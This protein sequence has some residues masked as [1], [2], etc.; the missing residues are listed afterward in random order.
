MSPARTEK[1]RRGSRKNRGRLA[2][3]GTL[4]VAALTSAGIRNASAQEAPA[5]VPNGTTDLT[6][7]G[8][9]T[10]DATF[11][12]ITYSPTA[13]TIDTPITWD[14]LNDLDS[15][16][17][18]SITNQNASA[19]STLTLSGGSN[20]VAPNPADLIY[21]AAGGSLAID[22]APVAGQSTMQLVLNLANT[23]TDN[24]DVA[25]SLTISSQIVGSGSIEIKSGGTVTFAPSPAADNNASYTG[26]VTIENGTVDLTGA[27]N[28]AN[29]D[30][31]ATG[32]TV[33]FGVDSNN[34]NLNVTATS[35]GI[36]P[37]FVVGGTGVDTI[38]S[39]AAPSGVNAAIFQST[40]TFTLSN[41]LVVSNLYP[42]A[43]AGADVLGFR[44]AIGA[45]NSSYGITVAANN[46]GD[47]DLRGANTFGGGVTIDGGILSFNASSSPSSAGSSVTSGPFGTGTVTLG[48]IAADSATLAGGGA[49][50]VA[51]PIVVAAETGSGTRTI[52]EIGTGTASSING[53]VT[54]DAPLI[55][56]A[57]N[58]INSGA[59]NG[60]DRLRIGAGGITGSFNIIINNP[61]TSTVLASRD[62]IL[63]TGSGT[64]TGWTGNL[65][66][67]AGDGALGLSTGNTATGAGN[68][69]EIGSGASFDFSSN[70]SGIAGFSPTVAG[71]EDYSTISSP[72]TV[73]ESVTNNETLTLAGSG[74]YS[75]SGSIQNSS[76]TS[77]NVALTVALTAGGTQ[78]L[79]GS[80]TYTGP[81]TLTSGTLVVGGSGSATGTSTVTLNG[82]TFAS[83][84][85]A[86]VTLT[87]TLLAG[88]GAH[89]I[90][91]G[92]VDGVGT[93]GVAG[94]STSSL[95]TLEFQLGTGSGTITNGSQ[96]ILTGSPGSATIGFGTNLA[97]TGTTAAGNDYEL[98]GDTSSGSVV[99]GITLADFSLPA[100]PAGQT[101]SLGLVGGFIDL[102]V[103][104]TGPASLYWDN[105][106]NT[107]LWN[108]TD[109]NWNS[110]S[111]NTKYS[112]GSNVTFNDSN[113][114][115]Y[116]VTLNTT[117]SPGSVTVNSSGNYSITGGGTIVDTGAFTKTGTSTLTLGVGLTASSLAISGGNVVLASSTTAGTG[118]AGHPASNINVTSLTIATNSVLDITN[119]HIIIDYTSSDPIST[120]YGYLKTGFNNGAWN[121]TSGIISSTAQSATNGLHYG[122]GWADGADGTKNVSGLSSGQILLKYTL[123]GDANLD[124]T[125]NGSD[126]SILAANFGLGVTNWD[127]GNFL[128]GSSVNGS[129][130]SAL[131]ANFG[132]GDSG[133]ATVTPAD[134]AA[135]DAF[136]AANGLP[137]PTIDAVPEPAA[138]GLA[139]CAGMGVLGRRR[140]KA[141]AL[142]PAPGTPGEG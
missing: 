27:T 22:G 33:F 1:M 74:A 129:D 45:T 10:S 130:F 37:N 89:T 18:L 13:F 128:F 137:Q 86:N 107:G 71:L 97:F 11:T 54:L 60:G 77:G 17:S 3:A 140:R 110:G 111:G 101:Y 126:F 100:V 114:G 116:A 96:L 75:F 53:P 88:S 95:T 50:S 90:V 83:L 20:T 21:V 38:T 69:V 125:V 73:Y 42:E 34:V 5:D 108:T 91:P 36:S 68:I 81:T 14:T 142:L 133:A 106:A 117:V 39:S 72:S 59:G 30:L 78:T 4:A 6:T 32:G 93:L 135:L 7:V 105:G 67:E 94:I 9:S 104:S 118:S 82:G 63:L 131:A 12:N 87:S 136:A 8:N 48:G 121:G 41:N 66:I 65:I 46:A 24:F 115:N 103:G 35:S 122:V 49:F 98:I 52:E 57:L 44:G 123:L 64:A 92:G 56:T 61:Y 139:V 119:N 26:T 80:S 31:G 25:G 28:A 55:L 109:S 62:V 2:V 113:G 51:N 47:V 134:I 70:V 127:Q 85:G 40:N 124:G 79:T 141:L 43:S 23:S 16:Q 132:Q 76:N 112:D 29:A 138:I 120:I 19:T 102:V 84:A 58:N 99:S 15:T